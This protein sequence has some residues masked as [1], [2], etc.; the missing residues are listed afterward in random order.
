MESIQIPSQY[1]SQSTRCLNVIEVAK[2]LGIGISTVWQ[3]L[4]N[5]PSFPRSFSLFNGGNTT[6]W[7]ES[8]IDDYISSRM[9]ACV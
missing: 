4:K 5:D 8:D 3:K 7:R 6:R 9:Q 2:K 1:F